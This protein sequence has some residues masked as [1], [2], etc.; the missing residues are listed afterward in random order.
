MRNL[1]DFTIPLKKSF[2]IQSLISIS[3]KKGIFHYN[4]NN[5]TWFLLSAHIIMAHFE[6]SS[7]L[8]IKK[9]PLAWM[10]NANDS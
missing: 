5:T 8:N 4:V 1:K 7:P 3:V 9:A 10:M 6:N 2:P